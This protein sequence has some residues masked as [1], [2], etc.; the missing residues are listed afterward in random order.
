M[1]SISNFYK[2]LIIIVLTLIISYSFP[3]MFAK[4]GMNMKFHYFNFL[5]VLIVGVILIYDFYK[6]NFLKKIV[7]LFTV[8]LFT[9]ISGIYLVQ[10]I[11]KNVYDYDYELHIRFNDAV[12]NANIIF[13]SI[14]VFIELLSFQII[15]RFY[16]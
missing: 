5:F 15:K 8:S 4:G 14:L 16:K 11:L 9:F 10:E 13:Y 12:F 1:K 7:F 2:T 6:I 3:S